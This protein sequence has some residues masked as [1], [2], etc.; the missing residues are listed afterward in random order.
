MG[1]VSAMSFLDVSE[2]MKG[3]GAEMMFGTGDLPDFY[4]ALDL[5]VEMAPYFALPSV[6]A[7]EMAASLPEGVEL[8]GR[9]EYVGVRVALAGFSWA[10]RVAQTTMEDLFKGGA[11][12]R[13]GVP[14]GGAAPGRG[15][16][17]PAGDL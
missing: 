17:P 8:P 14:F 5:G 11:S 4:Y 1:G 6:T 9:G 13:A 3:P 10:C 15:R 7:S 16:V 12:G 2:E